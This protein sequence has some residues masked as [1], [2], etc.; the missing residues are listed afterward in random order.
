ME[1]RLTSAGRSEAGR[2]KGNE[3][4]YCAEP[5]LGLFAVA[6]GVGGYEGGEV[7]SQLAI[8][9]L[10]GFFRRNRAD[11]EAT[12]PWKLDPK[13]SFA[14]N[15][16]S[17][18]TRLADSAISQ[19][20]EGRLA[21]MGSTLAGLVVRGGRAAIGHLGDSRIY[22]LRGG[23]LS[24]LTRD[25]SLWQE[26][27]DSGNADYKTRTDCPWG[28]VITRALG[29]KGDGVPE[30]KEVEVLRGDVFLLCSDGISEPVPEQVLG[31]ILAESEPEEACRRL[32]DEALSR[33]SKDNVTAVVVRVD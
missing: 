27:A 2:R 16:L 1:T 24:P 17:V 14:E 5:D 29:L 26:M 30:L 9:T 23:V 25:H 12:W 32:I 20:K 22:R 3:D 21:G 7:A 13:R 15:L 6:D 28:N 10:L 31:R 11:P 18:G 19:R 4:S 8:D 33:G